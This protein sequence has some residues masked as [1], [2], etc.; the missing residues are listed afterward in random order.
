MLATATCLT[1][2]PL[3]AT[4]SATL[5]TTSEDIDTHV[6]ASHKP[7]P[8]IAAVTLSETSAVVDNDENNDKTA[9]ADVAQEPTGVHE[10]LA[11]PVS[12][13]RSCD[14]AIACPPS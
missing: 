4:P 6:Y 11:A 12:E 3:I 10:T 2:T 1:T 5:P 9:Q 7:T 14:C 13:V 8:V